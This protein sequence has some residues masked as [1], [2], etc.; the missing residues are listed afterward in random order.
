MEEKTKINKTIKWFDA[1]TLPMNMFGGLYMGHLWVKFGWEILPLA[2][3]L[4]FFLG[5]STAFF[6]YLKY[7]I[8]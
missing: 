2:I 1:L 5:M 3:P 8:L 7:N 4:F 6:K